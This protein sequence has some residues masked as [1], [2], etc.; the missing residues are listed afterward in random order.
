MVRLFFTSLT[1][2]ALK[3]SPPL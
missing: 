1:H 3:A 2:K